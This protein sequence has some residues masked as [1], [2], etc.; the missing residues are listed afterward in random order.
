MPEEAIK[1]ASALAKKGPKQTL[2]DLLEGDSF[3][4]EVAKALPNGSPEAFIRAALTAAIR[5]P[6]LYKVSPDSLWQCLFD[7]AQMG[8]YPDGRRAHLIPFRDKCTLIV[9]YKGIAELAR[10]NGDVAYIHCD[11]V[12]EGEVYACEYGTAGGLRHI[13]DPDKEDNPIKCAYSFVKFAIGGT[14]KLVEEY[15]QMSVKAIERIRARSAAKDKG[16]WVTDWIEMA[17]KT[18]FRRHSKTLALSPETRRAVE[19]GEEE[20]FAAFRKAV[21]AVVPKKS[22]FRD[23]DDELDEETKKPA[24]PAQPAPSSGK[25]PKTAPQ[26]PEKTESGTKTEEYLF[27]ADDIGQS[28]QRQLEHMIQQAGIDRAKYF[29]WLNAIGVKH[30]RDEKLKVL[31]FVDLKPSDLEDCVENWEANFETFNNWLSK[32]Q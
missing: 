32:A 30:V 12:R 9:D 21:P 28:F 25:A 15:E 18:V 4:S 24:R 14:D 5:N 23:L 11:V 13:P 16:P 2:K 7:L 17:K 3:K 1:P 20:E 8:L 31:T 26:N 27:I 19:Y 6:D 29:E 22:E 10:R